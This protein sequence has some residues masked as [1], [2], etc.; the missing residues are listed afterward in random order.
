MGDRGPRLPVGSTSSHEELDAFLKAAGKSVATPAGGGRG[1]LAFALDATFS[2]Q[3]TWS[4]AQE[5]QAEMF[6]AA[7]AL[8]GLDVQ[9]IY[10]R[11]ARECRASGW[12][13]ESAALARLMGRISCEG[14]MTQIG[15]VLA[16]LAGEGERARLRAAVFVGD[17]VEEDP[18][19]LYEAA[20]RLGV[21]GLKLFLFQEGRDPQVERVFR[22][23]ARLSGGAWCAFAPGAGDEL[24]AL[25]RAVAAYAAGGRQA[26]LG[27]REGGAVRL[28]SAM[29]DR[30]P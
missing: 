10:Y 20:G 23:M 16:H 24:R 29:G 17:A 28:L 19:A 8:G 12:V 3:A 2:R 14:G 7:M 11:G 22:E 21:L 18:G 9:L 5:I 25:L 26:L 13:S 30:T 6:A 1:R 15:R 27:S 4:M